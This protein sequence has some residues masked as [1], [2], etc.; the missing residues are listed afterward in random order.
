LVYG[1]QSQ[2]REVQ[3]AVKKWENNTFIKKNSKP[4]KARHS[5]NYRKIKNSLSSS[6][7]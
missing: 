5:T 2:D 1:K 6:F 4:W 3:K 7:E